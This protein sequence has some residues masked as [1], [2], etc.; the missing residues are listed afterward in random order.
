MPFFPNFE[1]CSYLAAL[2]L[3][4]FHLMKSHTALFH[5]ETIVARFLS[6]I[7]FVKF[8][9]IFR[10]LGYK[11]HLSIWNFNVEVP[12][13]VS[14]C[15]LWQLPPNFL[16][17]TDNNQIDRN[18]CFAIFQNSGLFSGKKRVSLLP[19][20][21]FPLLNFVEQ[22][23]LHQIQWHEEIF[24]AEYHNMYIFI[25]NFK[26]RKVLK[27]LNC[28]ATP[29]STRFKILSPKE[30]PLEFIEHV[31][32]QFHKIPM[33]LRDNRDG[34]TYIEPCIFCVNDKLYWCLYL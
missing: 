26:V 23:N 22:N 9:L 34:W 8:S 12:L 32:H 16:S 4:Y 11:I 24:P 1:F 31:C 5:S 18:I 10:E 30:V 25:R 15:P 19:N 20:P 17:R 6:L 33:H 13:K 14:L 2:F 27:F 28:R 21:V 7:V 29:L 3:T